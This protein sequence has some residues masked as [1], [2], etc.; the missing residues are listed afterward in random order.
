MKIN[1]T[2]IKCPMLTEYDIYTTANFYQNPL[3]NI[4]PKS[5]DIHSKVVF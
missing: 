3:N 4:L 5:S 1:E 2:T